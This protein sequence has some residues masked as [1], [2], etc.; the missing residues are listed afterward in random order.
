MNDA[1]VL[2]VA[3]ERWGEA[4]PLPTV[5]RAARVTGG[6]LFNAINRGQL[7]PVVRGKGR[8]VQLSRDEAIS[9]LTAAALS[10]AAGIYFGTAL[11][12]VLAGATFP[13][14]EV[15]AA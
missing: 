2:D 13:L 7:H 1:A 8:A 12:A 9:V 15:V 3:F 4:V 14:P 5:A 10:F 11:R 6:D